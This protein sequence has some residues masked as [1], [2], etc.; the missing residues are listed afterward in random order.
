MCNSLLIG[1]WWG[2]RLVF[3]NLNHQPSGSIWSG[4]QCLCLAWSYYGFSITH[5]WMWELDYKKSWAPK[6]WCFWT[7]VLEKTLESPLDCKEIQPV[8]RKGD[9]S[10][11]FI[12]RTDVEAETSIL[13]MCQHQSTNFS[14]SLFRLDICIFGLYVCVSISAF[15]YL[16]S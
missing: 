16:D 12:G 1:C 6:N 14:H 5:V 2:S 11:M 4:V 7:V 10:W 13:Y 8:Q 9:Q 3:R 15:Q